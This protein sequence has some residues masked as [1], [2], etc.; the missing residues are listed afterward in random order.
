LTIMKPVGLKAY[1][2]LIQKK[3]PEALGSVLAAHLL[4]L[5]GYII[6]VAAYR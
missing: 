5:N 2:V 4:Y 1:K 6:N 3:C